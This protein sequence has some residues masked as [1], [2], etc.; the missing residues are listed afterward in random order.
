MASRRSV[1]WLAAVTIA[2]IAP[3]LAASCGSTP[4]KNPPLTSDTTTTTTTTTTGTGGQGGSNT[5]GAGGTGGTAGG[6]PVT[7]T[8]MMTDG[9]ETDM[10]CGG[11]C[12]PCIPGKACLVD[13]DCSSVNCVNLV[14]AA[15]TCID[16]IKNQDE[17]DLNCGGVVC[18]PCNSGKKCNVGADCLSLVCTNHLCD[19]ESCSDGVKNGDETDRDCGGS[20]L[21]CP[22]GQHCSSNKDCSTATC[23]FNGGEQLCVC[24]EGML[25][26]PLVN[27]NNYCMDATEVTY[28]QYKLFYSAAPA[29]IQPGACSAWN[30]NFTPDANWP[31]PLPPAHHDNYPVTNVN[32]C[33]AYSYCKYNGKHLCGKVGGGPNAPA[34]LADK[35]KSEW[36]IACSAQDQ[37][38]Y[39][40]GNGFLPQKCNGEGYGYDVDGGPLSLPHALPETGQSADL[41]ETAADCQG[42]APNLRQMSGNVAEWEDSCDASNDLGGEGDHC[43]LRGGSYNSSAAELLC[44]ANDLTHNRGYSADDVGFRCCL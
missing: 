28:G 4:T 40:Y 9:D 36:Y 30:L 3:A 20:C 6:A 35:F 41:K 26:I 11:S 27:G 18:P 8:D 10:D 25:P 5:G 29:S 14:C 2:A 17:T 38:A 16:E 22:A 39:P 23:A 33:D 42:G 31:P 19:K 1:S 7:C 13:K 37:S 21:P 24:P 43:L 34:D 44:K 15:P 12:S 32:W